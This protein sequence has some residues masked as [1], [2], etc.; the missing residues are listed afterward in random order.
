LAASSGRSAEAVTPTVAPAACI[1]LTEGGECGIQ[2]PSGLEPIVLHVDG[3]SLGGYAKIATVISADLGKVGFRE[4]S[5]TERTGRRGRLINALGL[6]C[7]PT[8]S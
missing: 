1:R 2:V 4:V 7:H 5:R 3:P 8:L 6:R